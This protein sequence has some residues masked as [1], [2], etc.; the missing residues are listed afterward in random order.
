M[1]ELL[2]YSSPG[3]GV[4]RR[5]AG[6]LGT[7]P[8]QSLAPFTFPRVREKKIFVIFSYQLCRTLA[9]LFPSPANKGMLLVQSQKLG[10][11]GLHFLSLG[12]WFPKAFCSFH[13]S[14]A[15]VSM[16]IDN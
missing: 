11:F 5:V 10:L 7:L 13:V 12:T 8:A 15:P 3:R 6:A 1:S 4:P 2:S 14:H 9:L 16:A